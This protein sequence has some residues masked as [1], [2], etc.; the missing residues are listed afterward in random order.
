MVIKIKKAKIVQLVKGMTNKI[1]IIDDE[2]RTID[3]IRD[4]LAQEEYEI[5]T[6]HNGEEALVKLKEYQPILAFLDIKMPV[7]NG[8]EFLKQVH[9]HS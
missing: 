2:P 3:A 7:M 9:R 8:I 4:A 1:L 6:A 5:D